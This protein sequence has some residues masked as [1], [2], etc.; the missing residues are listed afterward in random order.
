MAPQTPAAGVFNPENEYKFKLLVRKGDIRGNPRG[1]KEFNFQT[2][3]SEGLGVTKA[4]ALHFVSSSMP[5]AQL[6]NEDLYFKKSKGAAQSQYIPL[7][8]D[9]F[10]DLCK[11]RWQLISQRDVTTMTRGGTA[12]AAAFTFEV[13]LYIHKRAQEAVPTGLRRATT[14]RIEAAAHQIR[15]YEERNNVQLGPIT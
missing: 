14:G 1:G 8:D 13:F 15:A 9:T 5:E 4:K 6:I 7:T 3:I 2:K 11:T 10:S 12:L